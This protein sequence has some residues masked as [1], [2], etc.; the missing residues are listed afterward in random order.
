MNDPRFQDPLYS[1][2]F[3]DGIADEQSRIIKLLEANTMRMTNPMDNTVVEGL[4][5]TPSEFI[6]LIKGE[7]K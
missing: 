4:R 1:A 5:I 6:A 3:V 2:G 7:N